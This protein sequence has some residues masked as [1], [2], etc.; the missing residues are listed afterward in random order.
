MRNTLQERKDF[1]LSQLFG[2]SRQTPGMFDVMVR[3][4]NIMQDRITRSR[5]AGDPPEIVLAPR[6]SEMGLLEFDQADVA[7]RE[8][9]E[10]VRRASL[11]LEQLQET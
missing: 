5:M 6:L 7:I 2:R 8:G 10:C 4:I 9:R 3:S 1:L 11:V